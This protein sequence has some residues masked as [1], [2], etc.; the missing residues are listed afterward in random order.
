MAR[1]AGY[2]HHRQ[3]RLEPTAIVQV[4]V[5]FEFV[6]QFVFTLGSRGGIVPQVLVASSGDVF[7]DAW[8]C[9]LIDCEHAAGFTFCPSLPL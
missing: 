6:V 1:Y 2:A 3:S 8:M 4:R 5:I 9:L 7:M